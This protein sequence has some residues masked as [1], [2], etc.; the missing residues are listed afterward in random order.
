MV[1]GNE[2]KGY[3]FGEIEPKAGIL[4]ERQNLRSRG[5][6]RNPNCMSDMFLIP[7][8]QPL[9]GQPMATLQ[10]IS[11]RYKRMAGFNVLHPMG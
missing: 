8:E 10:S 7:L 11:C 5:F 3:P 9:V 6:R 1:E 4:V 2:S